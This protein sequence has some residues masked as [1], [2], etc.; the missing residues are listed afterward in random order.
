MDPL[1][2]EVT[3][4]VAGNKVATKFLKLIRKELDKITDEIRDD[5][6]WWNKKSDELAAELKPKI[7]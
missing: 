2:D 1:F 6:E 3:K 4:Q 7:E 5:A